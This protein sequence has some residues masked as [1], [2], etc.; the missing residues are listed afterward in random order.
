M[1]TIWWAIKCSCI[2]STLIPSTTFYASVT[3]N[4]LPNL[5]S[6]SFVSALRHC[7]VN[8]AYDMC[9][10]RIGWYYLLQ[11]VLR[12]HVS[13]NS[14]S[15]EYTGNVTNAVLLLSLVPFGLFVLHC[16]KPQSSSVS[17]FDFFFLDT[18][19]FWKSQRRASRAER[20]HWNANILGSR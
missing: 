9:S 20:Q 3:K 2:K 12:Y 16:E 1:S 18:L 19:E 6:F 8:F 11:T 15:E 4:D 17:H 13:G 14:G 10:V 7:P 5:Q